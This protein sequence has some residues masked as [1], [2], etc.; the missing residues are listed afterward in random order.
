MG[1]HSQILTI[2]MIQQNC[3][4]DLDFTLST[5]H[6]CTC[7]FPILEYNYLLNLSCCTALGGGYNADILVL[8]I[9]ILHI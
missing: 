6:L 1:C 5:L 2:K 4:D 8:V 9:Y 3:N 7:I